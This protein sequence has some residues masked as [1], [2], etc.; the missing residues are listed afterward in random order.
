VNKLITTLFILFSFFSS[1][2]A[3]AN[4]TEA[5]Q[6]TT[7]EYLAEETLVLEP[8]GREVFTSLPLD[9]DRTYTLT[10]AGVI[11]HLR[12]T[13]SYDADA[14]YYTDSTG[15]FTKLHNDLTFNTTH[16]LLSSDRASHTYIFRIAGHGE[17]LSIR[18]FHNN[19][20]EYY[21]QGSQLH[22]HI[23]RGDTRPYF[24]QSGLL[25][26]LLIGGSLVGVFSLLLRRS[27]RNDKDTVSDQALDD[28]VDDMEYRPDPLTFTLK[29]HP[30]KE[31]FSPEP[32]PRGQLLKVSCTGTYSV[33]GTFPW[34]KHRR[35]SQSADACYETRASINFTHRH[36]YLHLDGK[37][38]LTE[39][40]YEDRATH[41][42]AF[43]YTGTG[44]RLSLFL[45][46]PDDLA[47]VMGKLFVTVCHPT[48]EEAEV[49][50]AAE[51][52]A[53]EEEQR[54]EEQERAK[55]R[56]REEE[57][58]RREE[59]K[60]AAKVR[61]IEAKHQAR[62]RELTIRY[63]NLNHYEDEGWLKRRA[64]KY[65]KDIL[66]DRKRIIQ[67]NAAF[68][69]DRDFIEYLKQH[70]AHVYQRATWE[71]KLLALAEQLDAEEVLPPPSPKETPQ[72]Y[73]ERKLKQLT[74][75]LERTA[76]IQ[77]ITTDWVESQLEGIDDEDEREQARQR[78]L[79][80][81]NRTIAALN[82]PKDAPPTTVLGRKDSV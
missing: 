39:P 78:L 30:G 13:G 71:V 66:R 70:A 17:K 67:E 75:S 54:K 81:V 37:P 62:L 45:K 40:F 6:P 48:A 15:S 55:Q 80:I 18:L 69:H 59:E 44:N 10:V 64:E 8:N 51:R 25:P 35:V 41:S 5:E 23:V 65:N 28:D 21:P 82:K 72:Q 22:V 32:L 57:Q 29:L 34:S 53:A 73:F 42:Y 3:F 63:Q 16:E 27:N 11:R 31:L 50:I 58:R 60:Q 24:L 76:T 9:P 43:F 56:V 19:R 14:W 38:V 1:Q 49:F 61:E 68:H 4:A 12:W 77:Q 26:F 79:G 74:E 52:R 20:P 7:P 36:H 33:N 2:F 46:P 47:A